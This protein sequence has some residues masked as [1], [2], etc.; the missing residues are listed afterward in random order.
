M[1]H[2]IFKIFHLVDILSERGLLASPE[3]IVMEID[4]FVLHWKLFANLISKI[5]LF[6]NVSSI[7][8]APEVFIFVIIFSSNDSIGH[9]SSKILAV[10][11]LLLRRAEV[12]Q[13]SVEDRWIFEKFSQIIL[14]LGYFN[15]LIPVPRRRNTPQRFSGHNNASSWVFERTHV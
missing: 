7:K 3:I 5:L 8:G 4:F 2:F 13:R 10:A 12:H 1:F 6:M 15:F 14:N 9:D 11:N